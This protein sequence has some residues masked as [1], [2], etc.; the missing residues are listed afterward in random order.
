[1]SANPRKPA[2]APPAAYPPL[3]AKGSKIVPLGSPV[4]P[5]YKI[6]PHDY[7]DQTM[8]GTPRGQR[9]A[10]KPSTLHEKAAALA[11]GAVAA[12]V[13][14]IKPQ[15]STRPPSKAVPRKKG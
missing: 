14:Y 10:T 9:N 2:A 1:L 3:P 7:Q 12:V 15:S 11:A 8:P 6:V 4:A 13:R 5:E